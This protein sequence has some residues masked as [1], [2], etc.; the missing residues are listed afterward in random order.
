MI[1]KIILF[2][3]DLKDNNKLNW[4]YFY[5]SLN[6]ETEKKIARF[7][8]Y[9]NPILAVVTILYFILLSEYVIPTILYIIFC[10]STMIINGF[11][12]SYSIIL[13]RKIKKEYE[14]ILQS[15]KNRFI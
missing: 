5:K 9:M 6:K 10:F 11:Y 8:H 1:E 2:F 4:T 3:Y 13:E 12:L 14:K 7:T 15:R